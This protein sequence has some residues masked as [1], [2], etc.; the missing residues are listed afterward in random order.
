M[1]TTASIPICRPGLSKFLSQTLTFRTILV[2]SVM[3]IVFLLALRPMTD[4]DIGWHLRNAEYLLHAHRMIR[5][6][7]YA[8]ST[9]GMPWINHEWLAEVPYYLGWRLWGA[10]GLLLVMVTTLEAIFLGVFW[11]AWFHSRN[12][13]AAWLVTSCAALFGTVSFGPRTLLFGWVALVSELLLLARHERSRSLVPT[14]GLV[15][16]RALWLLPPLF[17]VWINLHGSWL[18]GFVLLLCYGGCGLVQVQTGCIENTRWSSRELQYFGA[19]L[20]LCFGA[21]FANPYGWRLV[22]YPF[23]LAFRQKLNVATVQEWQSLDW[24][25]AR[26]EIFFA[27]LALSFAAQLLRKRTW[28]LHHLAFLCIGVYS[29][30]TYSRFLFLAAILVLPLLAR[31]IPWGTR[32][33][34]KLKHE[35][36]LNGLLLLCMV[37]CAGL[38]YRTKK[39]SVESQ[40]GMPEKALR[41]LAGLPADAPV[42]NEYS[43]GGYL[44]LHARNLSLLIDSRTDIFERKGVLRDYLD[45][46]QIRNS[47]TLLD[48]YRIRYVLLGP[49]TPLVYLLQHSPDWKTDY[50]DKTA[51]LMERLPAGHAKP[52]AAR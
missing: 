30:I 41:V 42:L 20:L 9:A 5:Q 34:G 37:V 7:M 3:S 32:Q 19:V 2:G 16:H 1:S 6:D 38:N 14:G 28:P 4:P 26:G 21:L 45:A 23:D 49:E 51:I 36:L 29:A 47:F 25:S 43:W 50:R 24:H 33:R 17:L 13:K 48:K 52:A 27:V 40:T 22:A 8:F 18:I 46:V 44:E 31:D 10:N 39:A 12:L 15:G 35:S 11:L